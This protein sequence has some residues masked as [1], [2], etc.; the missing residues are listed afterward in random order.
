MWQR[1]KNIPDELEYF[2]L[3][4]VITSLRLQL[5]YFGCVRSHGLQ[6]PRLLCPWGFSRQEYW[7]GLP[8]SPLGDLPKPG[9]EPGSRALQVESLPLNHRGSPY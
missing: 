5:S 2:F 1:E 6:P 3:S 8:S 9:I 7:S 4:H